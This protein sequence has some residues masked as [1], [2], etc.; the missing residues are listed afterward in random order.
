M[1]EDLSVSF[2]HSSNLQIKP[3]QSASQTLI[4]GRDE[5]IEDEFGVSQSSGL[6]TKEC[7]EWTVNTALLGLD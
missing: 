7:I 3:N 6:P 4:G 5:Q 2:Q 1:I